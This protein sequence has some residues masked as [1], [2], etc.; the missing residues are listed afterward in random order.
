[1]GDL[2]FCTYTLEASIC[3][4]LIRIFTFLFSPMKKPYL[5]HGKLKAKTNQLEN[6]AKILL[7]AADLI[8]QTP[9]CQLYVVGYDTNEPN[10]IFVTEIWDTKENHDQSLQIEG[11]REL[12]ME[13]MPLLDGPPTKGQE[14]QLL[15]GHGI[16]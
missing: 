7:D 6:L 4:L 8:S 3:Y 10:S 5:L 1:M 11:V 16:S 2:L 14:I 13:A 12:I 9:G 15:G